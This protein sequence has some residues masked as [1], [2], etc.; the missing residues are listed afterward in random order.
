MTPMRSVPAVNPFL[1][2]LIFSAQAFFLLGFFVFGPLQIV[3]A[4]RGKSGRVA[5][6]AYG[7]TR[8]PQ[9]TLYQVKGSPLAWTALPPT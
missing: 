8:D 1:G 3:L 7:D 9:F 4:W 5:F 2:N 6:D